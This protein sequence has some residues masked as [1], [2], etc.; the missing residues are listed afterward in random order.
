MTEPH[1]QRFSLKY[2]SNRGSEMWGKNERFDR[3]FERRDFGDVKKYFFTTEKSR[4]LVFLTRR[5]RHAYKEYDPTFNSRR[6]NHPETLQR[7]VVSRMA[8]GASS[9]HSTIRSRVHS[10][11]ISTTR[12]R[13]NHSKKSFQNNIFDTNF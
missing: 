5:T 7:C 9:P 1:K 12:Y 10:F 3:L 11:F 2:N 4:N 8:V 13:R 6:T